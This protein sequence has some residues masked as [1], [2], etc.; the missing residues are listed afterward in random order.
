MGSY[1]FIGHGIRLLLQLLMAWFA[2]CL[3][4][5]LIT[6]LITHLQ[7]VN[8]LSALVVQDH[9]ALPLWQPLLIQCKIWANQLHMWLD[10]VSFLKPY[11]SLLNR[12]CYIAQLTTQWLCIRTAYLGVLAIMLSLLASV[13]LI[14]GLT[15]R[16]IRQVDATR[17]S[18]VIYHQA[19]TIS[20]SLTVILMLLVLL[21]PLPITRLAYPLLALICVNA[22]FIQIVA[23]QFKKYL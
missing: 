16:Y 2:L 12:E 14:D 17:E 11:T 10:H 15:Q 20:L 3:A 19:K 18:A 9:Q 5:F 8:H 23:K 6:F 21:A 22:L 1:N 13:A 4:S 7:G